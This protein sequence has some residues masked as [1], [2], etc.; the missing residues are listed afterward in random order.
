MLWW[1]Q[2][3]SLFCPFLFFLVYRYTPAQQ[4]VAYA[5]GSKQRVIRMMEAQNDPM[6]P[7]KFKYVL[8]CFLYSSISFARMDSDGEPNIIIAY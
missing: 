6:E 5:S 7:P 8:A 4:G 2:F 1:S 3:C